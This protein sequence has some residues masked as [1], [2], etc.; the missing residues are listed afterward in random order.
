L[1]SLDFSLFAAGVKVGGAGSEPGDSVA[2]RIDAC[3]F[4]RHPLPLAA[5]HLQFQLRCAGGNR[6]STRCHF[7]PHFGD[8]SLASG[9]A[10]AGEEIPAPLLASGV[11][12]CADLVFHVGYIAIAG[13]MAAVTH[14]VGSFFRSRT[15]S[16]A[17]L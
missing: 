6:A 4:S 8:R 1:S 3:V 11:V 9:N 12:S 7:E 13:C 10:P 15:I 5:T 16:A 2:L 14:D 17:I